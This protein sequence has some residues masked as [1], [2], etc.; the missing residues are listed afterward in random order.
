MTSSASQFAVGLLLAATSLCNAQQNTKIRV[1]FNVQTTTLAGSI[2]NSPTVNPIFLQMQARALNERKPDKVHHTV[3]EA[4]AITQLG[5]PPSGIPN[6]SPYE[7]YGRQLSDADLKLAQEKSCDYVLFTLLSTNSAQLGDVP[8][9]SFP[10]PQQSIG[11]PYGGADTRGPEVNYLVIYRLHPISPR[12]PVIEGSITAHDTAPAYG[13]TMRA[14]DMVSA[15]V[16]TK[17]AQNTPTPAHT[18]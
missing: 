10:T 7:K 2:N 9:T 16:A 18:P 15:Q 6:Q 5:E 12:A 1:C 11:A 17:I 8:H 4:V 3:L 13:L 14:F